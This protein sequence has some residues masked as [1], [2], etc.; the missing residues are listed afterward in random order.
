MDFY[1]SAL[2]MSLALLLLRKKLYILNVITQYLNFLHCIVFILKII[3][4]LIAKTNF[5]Y[6]KLGAKL[7]NSYVCLEFSHDCTS[8]P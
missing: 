8:P 2:I 6:P 4:R 5:I 3:Q 7:R 1:N